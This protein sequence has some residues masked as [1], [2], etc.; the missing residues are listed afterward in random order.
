MTC[1]RNKKIYVADFGFDT[2]CHRFECRLGGNVAG[3]RDDDTGFV[4]KNL[5]TLHVEGVIEGAPRVLDSWDI[6]HPG[7]RAA[8]S[9]SFCSRRPII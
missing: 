1:V 4:F 8:A 7:K 6:T 9:L 2:F 3:K 5:V